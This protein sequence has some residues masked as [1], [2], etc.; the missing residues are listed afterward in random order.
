MTQI[1]EIDFE[2]SVGAYPLSVLLGGD[3]P[4]NKVKTVV[5][6]SL[7]RQA[8]NVWISETS[9]NNDIRRLEQGLEPVRVKLEQFANEASDVELETPETFNLQPMSVRPVRVQ[10]RETRAAQFSFA[11]DDDIDLSELEP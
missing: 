1:R 11:V 9:M 10:V 4:E 3:I 6:K 5:R 7:S 8:M 2:T